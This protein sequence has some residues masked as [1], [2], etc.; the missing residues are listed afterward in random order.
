MGSPTCNL[1]GLVL[2]N[3]QQYLGVHIKD[4]G[5]Y[6]PDLVKRGIL[7][8]TECSDIREGRTMELQVQ[9]FLEYISREERGYDVFVQMLKRFRVNGHVARY[10]QEKVDEM[11][12]L[13]NE[14]QPASI[15]AS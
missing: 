4:P 8:T 7:D 13:S 5:Q 11:D 2:I 10:L 9:K 12:K 6:F 3:E 1:K 14:G 15:L